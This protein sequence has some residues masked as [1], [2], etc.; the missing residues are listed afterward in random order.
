[1]IYKYSITRRA[2]PTVCDELAT[3]VMSNDYS[4]YTSG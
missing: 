2:T 4:K 1:M 3:N